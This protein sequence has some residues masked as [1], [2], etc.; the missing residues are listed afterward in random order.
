[1]PRTLFDKIWDAHLVARRGDGRD[2]IYIDRHVLHELHAPHAFEQLQKQQRKVRRP[3]LTFSMQDH[4]VATVP[5]RDESSNPSGTAFIRAMREGSR[6]N[7]I[8]LFD[9]DDPEQGISHVV[10]PE[11]GM[12][13]PGATHAVPD[14]HASTVGGVG[15]LAFGC[16]TSELA[17]ILATQVMALTRPKRMLIRIEG[18]LPAH[19]G[20]KDVALRILGELGVSGA[21]GHVVEYAGAAVRAMSIEARM[22]LCNLNIEMG[23]RSGFI[24]PDESTLSWLAGR[25][26]APSGEMWDRA[27]AGWRTLKSDAGAEFDREYSLDCTT[28]EPQITWGTDPSQVVGIR[29]RV[30]DPAKAEP[31]RRG[32]F[33]SALAYMGLEPGMALAGLPVQRVFIG[34]CT[35]SRLTDL[36]AAAN[37]V[38]GR[39]IVGGVVAMVVPGSTSVKRAAEATGLDRVF[40][41]AGFSWGESGCS[42]CAGGNGDRGT[43]GERCVSTTN[44]N[45]EH[46]QGPRVRTHLASPETAA[47]SAL[48]GRIADVRQIASAP[49]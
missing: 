2:L 21:R 47:A 43:P 12:V 37:V 36:E 17:H 6:R 46:R 40:R 44:R 42:M 3:D 49:A 34:S 33:E 20:A 5:G 26:F 8:R 7:G 45:F 15:A 30:P 11:L 32:A 14:S 41:D 16:G 31:T 48:A 28:L 38:R 25:P 18:R 39:R 24:A 4:T 22:T 1:M 9:I 29:G 13:L 19:V 10:A 27:L 35:N 23:G